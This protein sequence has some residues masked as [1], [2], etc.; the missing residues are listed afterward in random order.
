MDGKDERVW[1]GDRWDGRSLGRFVE[2][3]VI[4]SEKS[5]ILDLAMNLIEFR[6]TA[7]VE[8]LYYALIPEIWMEFH[9]SEYFKFHG[10]TVLAPIE[11]HPDR[12]LAEHYDILNYRPSPQDDC[13]LYLGFSTV[14]A[15]HFGE[16]PERHDNSDFQHLQDIAMCI[17]LCRP[18]DSSISLLA[19]SN[20]FNA[21]Y[22]A[23]GGRSWSMPY[24]RKPAMQNGIIEFE[25][26]KADALFEQFQ[27]FSEEAKSLIRISAR[28]LSHMGMADS[29]EDQLIGL[30]VALEAFF[31]FPSHTDGQRQTVG[32]RAALLHGKT[33]HERAENKTLF[34]NVYDSLSR[35]AHSGRIHKSY[36]R[37][38]VQLAAGMLK[39]SICAMIES[40]TAFDWDVLAAKTN[41]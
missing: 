19:M 11:D 36:D 1:I 27:K 22:L 21:P 33:E 15:C 14:E 24:S 41:S 31:L 16:K 40:G 7:K 5:E 35:T 39:Q 25:L 26:R 12:E 38:K 20:F 29:L 13:R 4:E 6:N 2:W 9:D 10:G 34:I 32:E 8:R 28:Y 3:V 30:R 23:F 17:N 37:D 18:V